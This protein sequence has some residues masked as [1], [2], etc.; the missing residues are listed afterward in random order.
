MDPVGAGHEAAGRPESGAPSDVV[1]SAIAEVLW[2]EADTGEPD[3]R[4]G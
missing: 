2:F 3:Q 1:D 4:N